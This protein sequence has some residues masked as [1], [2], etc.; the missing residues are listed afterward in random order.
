MARRGIRPAQPAGHRAGSSG[1]TA[2]L[3]PSARLDASSDDAPLFGLSF[4]GRVGRMRY[5]L[6]G[7]LMLTLLV[8]LAILVAL[9]PGRLTLALALLGLAFMVVWGV[10]LAALRLHDVNRSAWWALVYFIPYV[11]GLA[12]LVLSLW[13]GNADDN[14]HGPP[15]SQDGSMAAIGVLVVLCLS[16]SLGWQLAWS[17]F[18]HQME[19]MQDSAQD[20]GDDG[21]LSAEAAAGPALGELRRA[22][23]SD[24]AVDEFRRYMA[25]PGHRAFAVSSAG[26]WGW[27]AGAARV[28]QAIETS[29]ADCERRRQTYTAACQ[30][31]HVNDQWAMQ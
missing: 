4:E 20:E 27:H 30:L 18:Q 3:P 5:F 2:R 29:L 23:H 24:A 13:P 1:S 31:V 21:S 11:G 14:D 22:L 26:A 17:A 25:T 16:A 15:P 8:W 7:L 6:G 19:Q 10:R 9:A 12:S 28:E